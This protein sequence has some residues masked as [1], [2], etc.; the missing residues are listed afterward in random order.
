MPV[1]RIVELL[2]NEPA[3]LI[4]SEPQHIHPLLVHPL[5]EDDIRNGAY[6]AAPVAFLWDILQDL[7]ALQNGLNVLHAL[8]MKQTLAWVVM[9]DRLNFSHVR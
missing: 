3:P 1:I 5:F 7:V 6:V 9:N 8:E 4:A 2:L